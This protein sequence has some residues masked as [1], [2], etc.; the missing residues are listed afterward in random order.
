ME[1]GM[2]V[3]VSIYK[4][5]FR[6]LDKEF[7]KLYKLNYIYLDDEEYY[8]ILDSQEEGVIAKVDY[9]GSNKDIIPGAD[10]SSISEAHKMMKANSL[11]QKLMAGLPL[12]PAY[13][14]RQVLEAEGHDNVADLMNAPPPQP[15]FDMQ[16]KMEE[17]QHKKQMDL[18]D[19]QIRLATTKHEALKDFAQAMSLMAK[20]EATSEAIEREDVQ[21]IMDFAM[22]EEEQLLKK[23]DLLGK[24]LLASQTKAEKQT[25]EE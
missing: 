8:I 23:A 22:R 6:S 25:K 9:D 21:A 1:Q 7:K 24:Q 12:N 13:V 5:I 11:L 18:G 20:A 16:L 17:F 19:I 15:D 4:R 2:K 3:F 14:T 10:P